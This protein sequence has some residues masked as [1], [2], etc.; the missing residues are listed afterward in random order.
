MLERAGK[1]EKRGRKERKREK[2]GEERKKKKK[3]KRE[4]RRKEGKERRREGRRGEERVLGKNEGRA[5][6][7]LTSPNCDP[8]WFNVH[9]R[10]HGTKIN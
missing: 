7:C 1:G 3:R 4:E 2:K 10:P 5:G 9:S 6:T 8:L